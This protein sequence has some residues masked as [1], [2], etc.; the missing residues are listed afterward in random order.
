MPH[1]HLARLFAGKIHG[2]A[3]GE[4]GPR[5][6]R[7]WVTIENPVQSSRRDNGD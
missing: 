6:A 5:P 1:A 2:Q 7:P 4:A 3:G